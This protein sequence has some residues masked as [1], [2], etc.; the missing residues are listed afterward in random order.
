MLK[1]NTVTLVNKFTVGFFGMILFLFSGVFLTSS[2]G[3]EGLV[4]TMELMHAVGAVDGIRVVPAA[5][6]PGKIYTEDYGSSQVL[7]IIRPDMG[8]ISVSRLGTTCSCIQAFM[9][10]KVFAQGERAL[11]EVRNVRPSQAAGAEYGVFVVLSSP[12]RVALQAEVFVKSDRKPGDPV[13][14]VVAVP[15]SGSGSVPAPAPLP[16]VQPKFED[17][18][19]YAPKVRQ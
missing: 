4:S 6:V 3:G 13:P 7:E 18:A 16:P 11:V 2:H 14:A 10:K 12:Y 19:P 1:K 15:G 5:G 17:I 9:E 8:P